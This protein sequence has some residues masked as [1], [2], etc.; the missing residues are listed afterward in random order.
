MLPFVNRIEDGRYSLRDKT[1][2][3]EINKISRKNS[4]HGLVR[5]QKFELIELHKN[6]IRFEYKPSQLQSPGY[7]KKG[8]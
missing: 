1:Y 6:L 8:L 5:N 3:L 4:I 2:Q 7:P